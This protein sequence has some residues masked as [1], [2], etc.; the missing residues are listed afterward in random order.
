MRRVF[1]DAP[2]S[3][4][5]A[6]IEGYASL[7]NE[8]DLNDDIV[9]PGAF[10]RSLRRRPAAE[11]KM[12]FHHEATAPIGVWRDIREDDRGLYVRGD[13]ALNLPRAAETLELMQL[14]AVDGL[15]IGFRAVRSRR[16]PGK[17]ARELLEIDLWEISVVTFPMAPSAR[18]SAVRAP[19]RAGGAEKSAGLAGDPFSPA[20]PQSDVRLFTGAV[21]Q[22]ARILREK[23]AV[24]SD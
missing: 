15:S 9:A 10:A 2:I 14:G 6:E 12:L 13:L 5:Y 19:A 23:G 7:F 11:V 24:A 22:A 4:A 16:S 1:D 3:H 17:G 21:R 20:P 18:V 8:R